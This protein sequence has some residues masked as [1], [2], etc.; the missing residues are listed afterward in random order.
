MP[1]YDVPA[2]KWSSF[3]ESFSHDHAGEAISLREIDAGGAVKPSDDVQTGE[4]EEEAGARHGTLRSICCDIGEQ[5]NDTPII[6]INVDSMSGRPA[7][8]LVL[9]AERLILDQPADGRGQIRIETK[10]ECVWILE[11]SGR[12][13][14]GMLNGWA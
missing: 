6:A 12:V 10:S 9:D 13:M 4:T 2:D 11:M 7:S 8:H 5:E 14:P 3:C 1:V